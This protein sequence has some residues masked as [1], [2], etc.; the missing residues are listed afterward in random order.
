MLSEKD[1][2][3]AARDLCALRGRDPDEEQFVETLNL[4]PAW[5]FVARELI[6]AVRLSVVIDHHDLRRRYTA[7]LDDQSPV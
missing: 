5:M 1:V 7:M 2:E 6:E 3:A 4:E